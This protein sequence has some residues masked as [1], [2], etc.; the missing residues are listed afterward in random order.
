MMQFPARI[1]NR[2][3][4]KLQ[5]ERSAIQQGMGSVIIEPDALIVVN[6]NNNNVFQSQTS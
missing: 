4:D 1:I 2:L 5:S 3:H 6:N